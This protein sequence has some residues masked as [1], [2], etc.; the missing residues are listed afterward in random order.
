MKKEIFKLFIS[1]IV[2]V[3]ISYI[4]NLIFAKPISILRIIPIYTAGYLAF[5]FEMSSSISKKL[6]IIVNSVLTILTIVIIVTL[7]VI[8][9]G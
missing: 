8:Y 5:T 7:V 3:V 6:K 9:F 1:L 4:L 2:L